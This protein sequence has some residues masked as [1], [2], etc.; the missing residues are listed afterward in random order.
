MIACVSPARI[1]RVTPLRISL[2][3]SSVAT[4]TWRSRI[5][6]VLTVGSFASRVS[7]RSGAAGSGRAVERGVDVDEDVVALDSHGVDRDRLEGRERRGLAGA[8]V[9]GRAVQPALDGAA[10]V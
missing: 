2:A 8:Q 7:V 3:P 9:E 1:V 5:S 4:V 10:A 6:R